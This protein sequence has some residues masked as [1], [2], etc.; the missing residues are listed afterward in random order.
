MT[1]GGGGGQPVRWL[2]L[3]A[4]DPARWEVFDWLRDR[5]A[6]VGGVLT[7]GKGMSASGICSVFRSMSRRLF[8]R[9]KPPPSFYALRH[10]ACAEL[11]A[12]GLD[13]AGV[14]QGMGHASA[15][16]QKIYGTMGQG[17]T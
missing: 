17:V 15:L 14:A 4:V 3:S 2:T 16:S 5:V 12:G 6:A 7:V 10:A 11:K 13:V 9:R 8:P 1:V